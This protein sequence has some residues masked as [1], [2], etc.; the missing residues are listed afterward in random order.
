MAMMTP[1]NLEE[2]ISNSIQEGFTPNIVN[3]IWKQ[4]QQ[5]WQ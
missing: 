1:D 2:I 4:W 5:K 3:N